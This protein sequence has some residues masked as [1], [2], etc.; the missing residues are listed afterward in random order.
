MSS[1]KEREDQWTR[2]VHGAKFGF[3]DNKEKESLIDALVKSRLCVDALGEMTR[4]ELNRG[5]KEEVNSLL[6]EIVSQVKFEE[7][8]MV[9]VK[10]Q[11]RNNLHLNNL[12]VFFV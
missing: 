8:T 3:K 12:S 1:E 2:V 10:F 6:F 7:R 9:L 11:S 4:D 5:K